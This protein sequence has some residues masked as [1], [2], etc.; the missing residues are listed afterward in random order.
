[1]FSRIKKDFE[2]GIEK[3]RWF[4]S[5]FSERVRIEITIFKLLYK[6]EELKKQRDGLLKKIGEEV[7]EMRVKGKN[8]YANSEVITAI[9]DLEAI[10]PEIKE[11]LEKASEISKIVA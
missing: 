5:L 6:S 9:K 7:Y 1:M 2:N 11:T 3:I 10:E 4:A 8:V